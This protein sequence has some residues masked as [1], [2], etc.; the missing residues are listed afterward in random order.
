MYDLILQT[1]FIKDIVQKVIEKMIRKKI[2]KS[3]RIRIDDLD[4]QTDN[5]T[6]TI[7]LN[8]KAALYKKDF[9]ELLG[10]GGVI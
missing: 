1:P 5:D 2:K 4:I 9:L 6:V 3:I 7:H 10:K 8:A